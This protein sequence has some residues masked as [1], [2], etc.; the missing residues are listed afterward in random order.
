MLLQTNSYIVPKEKRAAHDKLMKR[1]R[2]VLMKIGCDH[3]EVYEQVG[4]NWVGGESSG[5]FVQ[6]MKF[7]DRKHCQAVQLIERKTPAAQALVR[8]FC[9]LI[10]FAYQQEQGLFAHGYYNAVIDPIRVR[11][12]DLAFHAGAEGDAAELQLPDTQEHQDPVVHTNAGPA[13][14][15]SLSGNGQDRDPANAFGDAPAGQRAEEAVEENDTPRDFQ[16][17]HR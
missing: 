1:F 9:D 6:L 8:E 12:S 10:N 2:Q 14:L 17:K 13:G 4:A 5:R 15:R 11:P 16:D 7:R 3:F